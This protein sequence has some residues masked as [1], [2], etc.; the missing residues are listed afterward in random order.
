MTLTI[1]ND[2]A[3]I[4]IDPDSDPDIN[5]HMNAAAALL[6]PV[7]RKLGLRE[8]LFRFRAETDDRDAHTG[9]AAE[10]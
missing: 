1:K 3:E 4:I 2:R 8:I 5:A 6:A 7:A 9:D 10:G